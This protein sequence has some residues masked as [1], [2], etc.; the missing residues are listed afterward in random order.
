MDVSLHNYNFPFLVNSFFSLDQIATLFPLAIP[1][2]RAPPKS[3]R[4]YRSQ[5]ATECTIYR[6]CFQKYF[7][8]FPKY[9]FK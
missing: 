6:P 2:W 8:E 4:E 5:I 3:R 1:E 9:R 7:S